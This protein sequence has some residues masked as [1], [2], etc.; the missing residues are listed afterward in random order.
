MSLTTHSTAA[1]FWKLLLVACEHKKLS[2]S[3]IPETRGDGIINPLG[4]DDPPQQREIKTKQQTQTKQRGD[5]I[6]PKTLLI[7]HHKTLKNRWF[8][9]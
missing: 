7:Y 8:N 9:I 3:K 6:N 1:S 2:V 5:V 4:Q